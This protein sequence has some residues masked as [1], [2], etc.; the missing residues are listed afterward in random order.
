MGTSGNGC[1]Y[2]GT[3]SC[4]LPTPPPAVNAAGV[5]PVQHPRSVHSPSPMVIHIDRDVPVPVKTQI[6]GHIEYAIC[7]G[8]LPPGARLPNVHELAR[9]L[10]VSPI[11]VSGAYADLRRRGLITSRR[12]LGTFV[13]D[14]AH[15]A[16]S[17]DDRA[18]FERELEAAIHT[19]HRLGIDRAHLHRLIDARYPV[20]HHPLTLAHV[21]VFQA[22]TAGYATAVARQLA[23]GDTITAWAIHELEGHAGALER[24]RAADAILALPNLTPRLRALVGPD[25]VVLDVPVGPSP[26]TLRRIAAIPGGAAVGVVAAFPEFLPIVTGNVRAHAP[27]A[28]IV[29]ACI[30]DPDQVAALIPRCDTLVVASGCVVPHA[31]IPTIEYLHVPDAQHVERVVAPALWRVRGGRAAAALRAER[32]G[33]SGETLSK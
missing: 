9:D 4:T 21:G 33:Q 31:G 27:A 25:A 17:D 2:A 7:Y 15:Q 5:S 20:P 19:A 8:S 24:V 30:D 12:G 13:A 3:N 29:G 1:Y 10:R 14:G 32:A 26:A 28:T 11:T 22:T 6:A 18:R 23:S 16:A